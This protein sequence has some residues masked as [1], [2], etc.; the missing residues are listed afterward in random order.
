MIGELR[1]LKDVVT[2]AMDG[3]KCTACG[4]CLEVCPHQVL[5][6]RGKRVVIVDRDACMECGACAKNCRFGAISVCTGVGC[7]DAVINSVLRGG[8]PCCDCGG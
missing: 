8:E 6:R 7:A 2:L 4:L 5:D 1:Y 3:D